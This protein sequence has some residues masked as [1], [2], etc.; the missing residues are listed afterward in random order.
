MTTSDETLRVVPV[1]KSLIRPQLMFGCDRMLVFGLL[2]AT[3]L[4]IGP[5]GLGS[6]NM[7]NFGIGVGVLIVG[8]RLL[9]ALAK[10]DPDARE[11]FIRSMRFAS[12]YGGSSGFRR[13]SKSFKSTLC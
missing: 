7:L 9:A 1:H 3:T 2:M 5:G 10:F 4:L 6:G 11:V 13:K 12:V 8:I